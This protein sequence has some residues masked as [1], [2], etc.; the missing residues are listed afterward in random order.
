D[1]PFDPSAFDAIGDGPRFPYWLSAPATQS[2]HAFFK[3]LDPAAP[4]GWSS[5]TGRDADGTA[6]RLSCLY[7]DDHILWAKTAV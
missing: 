3:T 6:C 5:F 2:F 4:H 7:F 1:E